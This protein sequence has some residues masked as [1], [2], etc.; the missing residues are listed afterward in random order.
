[1]AEVKEIEAS[2]SSANVTVT[3]TTETVVITS[4]PVKLPTRTGRAIVKAWAQHTNGT[5]TTAVTARLRRGTA[6]TDTLVNEANAEQVKTAAGS[7]EPYFSMAVDEIEAREGVQYS[8]TLQQTGASANGTT[9]QAGIEV[10][11]I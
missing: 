6:I 9:L 1:M 2:V 10:I 11:L 7:T 4:P 3:T 8:L 5:G